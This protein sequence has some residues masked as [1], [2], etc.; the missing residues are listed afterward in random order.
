M[1]EL[2]LGAD[3]RRMGR[4]PDMS[5]IPRFVAAIVEVPGIE[6]PGSFIVVPVRSVVRAC[7]SGCARSL[8]NQDKAVACPNGNER[9]E[10]DLDEHGHRGRPSGWLHLGGPVGG[11]V[12]N[13]NMNRVEE[14]N[15]GRH[16]GTDKAR[17][18]HAR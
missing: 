8:S 10:G 5:E 4:D 18:A 7:R 11:P 13:E 16:L 2:G 1:T 12:L 6:G 9:A 15:D 14:Q 17:T 3:S